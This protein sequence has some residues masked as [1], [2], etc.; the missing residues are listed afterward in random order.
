MVRLALIFGGVL[1]VAVASQ[2]PPLRRPARADLL[3]SGRRW[4]VLMLAIATM[5]VW[6][7]G[8]AVKDAVGTKPTEAWSIEL[9]PLVDQ[10]EKRG[11]NEGRV[12]VVPAQSHREASA[13]APYVNLA[14]GW[15]RQ[16]DTERNPISYEDELLT[17]ASYRAWLDRWAV[18]F[19]VLPTGEPDAAAEAETE[20]V[21]GGLGYLR[22]VWSD[23]YWRLFEVRNPTPLA[24]PP[25][26]VT[27]FDA[28]ELVLHVPEAGTILVRIPYSPWLSLVDAQG[29]AIEPPQENAAGTVVN[30]NGCLSDQ[31][32]PVTSPDE[33]EDV[34]TL[35]HAPDAGTYRIAAP[36]KLPRGTACPDAMLE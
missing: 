13:L 2:D 14:R 6:Q 25:A 27:Q 34:W 21:A 20:L 22:E 26:V 36:Y 18:H 23:A 32:Q 28:E 19:V 30:V 8:M 35:V 12:E 15:N 17:A 7:V 5:S 9:A 31:P 11:A 29:D 3:G 24:D 16:A 4:T 1:L 10:L 33:P